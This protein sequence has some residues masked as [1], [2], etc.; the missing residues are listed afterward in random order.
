MNNDD[1]TQFSYFND[2]ELTQL[3]EAE[4]IEVNGEI[5]KAL[6]IGTV[7]LNKYKIL[8]VLGE[9]SFSLIYLLEANDVSKKLL[10]AKEFF[11]KGF[12]T[13]N[14][15]NEVILK[16]SLSE[17]EIENYNFM[18][19]IF[20]GEAQ[21]LVKVSSRTH[22]N[23]LNFFSL[24]EN[25][26]NTM[27]LITDYEEGVTLKEY[28]VK[29]KE[30]HKGKIDNQEIKTLANG[31]LSGLEHIHNVQIY[32]QD[33]KLEN[34]LIRHDHTP[35]LLDFG[36]SIILYDKKRKKHFNATT[37]RYAAPE[38]VELSQ[39][40]QINGTSDI[41]A[42]GVLLY[43][44][45]TDEFPPKASERLKAL[46]EGK[47]DPYIPLDVQK[48][49]GYD[50]SLLSSIDKA[51]NLVQEKRFQNAREFKTALMYKQLSI[52]PIPILAAIILPIL[53]LL[54][55]LVWPN[56]QGTA[57]LNLK[58]KTYFVY[59][60]GKKIPL[61]EEKTILLPTGTHA[62]T[63]IKDG[64]IPYETN[65]SIVANQIVNVSAKLIPTS[66]LITLDS[67]IN[68]ANF[69]VNG[70]VITNRRFLGRAGE[71]YSIKTMALNH[72]TEIQDVSYRALSKY[73]FKFH[74]NLKLNPIQ[75]TININLPLNIGTSIVE[76]NG[77][78]ID[79]RTFMAEDGKSYLVR[80]SNPYYKSKELK[81]TFK[82]LLKKPIQTIVLNRGEGTVI[83]DGLPSGVNIEVYQRDGNHS[84]KIVA[85]I[86][87]S[88][89]RYKLQ[90]VA[91]NQIYF[92]VLKKGYKDMETAIFSL[93][94]NE[95]IMKKISLKKVA[96][97]KP[98]LSTLPLLMLTKSTHKTEVKKDISFPKTRV[99]KP[100]VKTTKV[101]ELPKT[102]EPSKIKQTEIVKKDILSSKTRVQ[103]PNVK[104]TKVKELP[105]TKEP[106]KTKQTEIVKKDIS[107]SKT[108][109]QKP[110]VKT[111]KVTE[112]PKKI[113]PLKVK[114]GVE[115]TVNVKK[116][117]DKKKKL[118]VRKVS[119]PNKK[120]VSHKVVKPVRKRVVQKK[121]VRKRVKPVK[122][123]KH[124]HKKVVKRRHNKAK[125][126]WYCIATSN[127]G[128]TWSA[129]RTT[130][131]SAYN[132]ALSRCRKHRRNFCQISSCYLWG[133]Q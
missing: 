80:V 128:G 43:K 59:S 28:L 56:S 88:K 34:I 37:P 20:I 71:H 119:K 9:G 30:T 17:K 91:S 115:Q 62:L 55:Y 107:S 92:K 116:T 52:P 121:P 86:E 106:S 45:V 74:Q 76:V 57:K 117:I 67:N 3:A 68:N 131:S 100:N 114:V 7:F 14:H 72:P 90:L 83:V 48:P 81:C 102:K 21:N 122:T 95:N 127:T 36:A 66:H 58:E 82:E 87:Y 129:K 54:I 38:Q 98:T 63:I 105:K 118:H 11:P 19:E 47:E 93:K 51:L 26:N 12:V 133:Q 22:P 39:P 60:D 108:R 32:H 110:N 5:P 69:T 89:N 65:V 15:A 109:V 123:K 94:N 53:G 24:E 111:T 25:V 124:R 40:P 13:R 104:T 75:V 70:N 33:I 125:N 1:A 101:K 77:T 8:K 18:K 78:K 42:L 79:K 46:D 31:L 6:E 113:E 120:K 4:Q 99:Q 103:K 112:V 61:S 27:Y 132:G 130:R 85:P 64:F 23:V 29:R 41:Y 97:V 50:M 35:L 49:Y 84:K 96:T 2:N 126:I 44:L 16:T 10:V 73:D